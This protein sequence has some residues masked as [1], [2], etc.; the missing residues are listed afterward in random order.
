VGG[1]CFSKEEELPEP[2]YTI[3]AVALVEHVGIGAGIGLETA[4]WDLLFVLRGPRSPIASKRRLRE[5]GP[6]SLVRRKIGWCKRGISLG[7]LT[8][9]LGS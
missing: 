4:S 7:P 9:T 2:D 5:F 6:C 1:F 3:P 8:S